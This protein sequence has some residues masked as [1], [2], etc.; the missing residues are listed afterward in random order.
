MIASRL[1]YCALRGVDQGHGRVGADSSS[2]LLGKGFSE[3]SKSGEDGCWEQRLARV[4][5]LTSA[6][7]GGKCDLRAHIIHPHRHIHII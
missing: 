6:A 1:W 7:M 4:E 5:K 2:A 3:G